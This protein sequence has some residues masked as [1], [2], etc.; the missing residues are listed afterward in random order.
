VVTEDG[1]AGDALGLIL[2]PLGAEELRPDRVR[3][4]RQEGRR[5]GRESEFSKQQGISI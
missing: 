4:L 1:L 5:G 2:E 3:G